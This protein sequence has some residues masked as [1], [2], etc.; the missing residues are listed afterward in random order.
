MKVL[1]VLLGPKIAVFLGGGDAVDGSTFHF[2]SLIS[3]FGPAAEILA[4]EQRNPIFPG[5]LGFSSLGRQR[6]GDQYQRNKDSHSSILP[7]TKAGLH[8]TRLGFVRRSGWRSL[9]RVPGRAPPPSLAPA[10]R[11]PKSAP[12]HGRHRRMRLPRREFR[13]RRPAIDPD[14]CVPERGRSPD[15]ADKPSVHWSVHPGRRR[16]ASSPQ[17][18]A[19]L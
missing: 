2:P 14:P 9:P 15:A 7:L 17:T 4:V 8:P 16:L 5:R 13:Q 19:T 11:F 6:G 3:D 10:A 1:E 12:T 18:R